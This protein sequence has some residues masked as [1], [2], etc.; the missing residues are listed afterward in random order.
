M[1]EM[2][3]VVFAAPYHFHVQYTFFSF[4]HS[5]ITPSN[6]LIAEAVP[7]FYFINIIPVFFFFTSNPFQTWYPFFNLTSLQFKTVLISLSPL[8]IFFL[9]SMFSI[10]FFLP[11]DAND[12][13]FISPTH[14]V[15]VKPSIQHQF[16][17]HTY[18]HIFLSFQFLL[19]SGY[20]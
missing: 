1:V 13:F 8:I 2:R 11:I 14:Y 10:T 3:N 16:H 17:F 18:Y 12:I 9:I 6:G 7:F 5:I 4:T 19:N 20:Q 15:M